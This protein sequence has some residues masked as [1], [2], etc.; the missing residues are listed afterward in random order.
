MRTGQHPIDPTIIR[1]Y[2]TTP[3]PV[4]TAVEALDFELMASFYAVLLV[5]LCR[6]DNL[7]LG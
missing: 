5:Y 7:A 1:R 2:R 6:Q 4:F 3:E